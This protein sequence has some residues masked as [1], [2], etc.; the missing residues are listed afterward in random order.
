MDLDEFI[1]ELTR[2]RAEL[3]Y[4]AEVRFYADTDRFADEDQ[5]DA[6]PRVEA[7]YEN[8]PSVCSVELYERTGR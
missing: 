5:L 1:A 6:E 4:N 3:G 7:D 2:V 8:E